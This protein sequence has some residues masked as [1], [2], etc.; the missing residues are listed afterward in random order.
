MS[1]T[2]LGILKRREP[3]R[4]GFLPVTDCAPLVYAREAG[5]F[6][7]YDVEVELQR[8]TSCAYV[9]AKVF[10]GELDA[11]QVPASLPFLASLGLSADPCECI[12]GLVLSLQGNAIAISRRLWDQGVLD[13][14][15]LRAQIYRRWGKQTYT[16]GVMFTGSTQELLLRQWLKSAG[17]APGVELRLVAIP[18]DQMFPTL[19]LGYI[20]GYCVSEPWT[21]V[22]VQAGA[23]VC[24]ATSADLA[25]LH[26]EQVLMVR[27]TFAAGRAEEHERLLAALLEACAFCD[28]PNNRAL[29]ADL[30]AQPHYVNAPAECLKTGLAPARPQRTRLERSPEAPIFHHHQANEPSDTKAAWVM[31]NLYGLLQP[32]VFKSR[33][34]ER[35][36]VLKNVFRNDIFERVK[37]VRREPVQPDLDAQPQEAGVVPAG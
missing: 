15:S 37:A 7:K 6:E 2:R 1:R 23:G 32:T 27:Q 14:Q 3:L 25:P 28:R 20:D 24:L 5:L 16:F 35:S 9:C 31:D 33:N 34:L 36:P 29:V 13:A 19:R 22:A 17:I 18:P 26:P 10:E 12:S 4:V 30:L 8:E 21:S 11:A